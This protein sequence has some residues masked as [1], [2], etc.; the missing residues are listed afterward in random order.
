[1][2]FQSIN[3]AL[4][5][6]GEPLCPECGVPMVIA[7]NR[8]GET[9]YECRNYEVDGRVLRCPLIE[10]RLDRRSGKMWGLHYEARPIITD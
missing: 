3:A 1:M 8:R 10:C 9:M 2:G 7:S 4:N 5:A 6:A